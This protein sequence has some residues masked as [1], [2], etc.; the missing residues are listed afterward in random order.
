MENV[1]A[2]G[3][4]LMGMFLVG[5]YQVQDTL[6]AGSTAAAANTDETR[7]C[8]MSDIPINGSEVEAQC[9]AFCGDGNRSED[10]LTYNSG[11]SVCSCANDCPK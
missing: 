7:G 6:A 3:L 1:L 4:A 9:D 5:C 8:I 2:V 11:H 10:Y